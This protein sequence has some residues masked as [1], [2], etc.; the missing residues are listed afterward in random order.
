MRFYT[1]CER[2]LKSSTKFNFWAFA[3]ERPLCPK[4]RTA[5]AQSQFSPAIAVICFNGDGPVHTATFHRYTCISL[6]RFR[7][8]I[9][10]VPGSSCEIQWKPEVCYNCYYRKYFESGCRK[11]KR[12]FTGKGF[13]ML[14]SANAC[15]KVKQQIQFL[16][17]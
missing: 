2:S 12:S 5:H 15:V 3:R 10:I 7:H 4:K 6:L 13:F 17:L 14:F 16:L 11:S 9:A 1:Y 8:Q